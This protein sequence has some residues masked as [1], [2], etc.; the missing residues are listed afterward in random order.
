MTEPHVLYEALADEFQTAI[1]DGRLPAGMRLPS[2]RE[3][4]RSRQLSINTV[5]AAYQLEARGQVGGQATIRL[6][7][8]APGCRPRSQHR[9]RSAPSSPSAPTA[10]CSTAS[11]PSWPHGE[12][13]HHRSIAGLP[14]KQRRLP[15]QDFQPIARRFR[16]SPP[17]IA[18]RLFATAR[19]ASA[20]PR[21]LSSRARSRHDAGSR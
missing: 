19:T 20:A 17:G 18:D 13:G 5:L 11:R 3:T 6:L 14:E 7:L 1:D 15:W 9:Y 12:S 8:S 4:A 2:I 21:N 10:Q 16:P